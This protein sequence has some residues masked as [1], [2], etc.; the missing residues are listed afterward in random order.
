MSG[1]SA[2]RSIGSGK[3]EIECSFR[4]RPRFHPYST[5]MPLDGFLAEC[6][7]QSGRRVFFSVQ[8]P[9]PV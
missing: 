1:R 6:Q 9:V 7:S 8:P 3:S 2:W 5:A 4:S